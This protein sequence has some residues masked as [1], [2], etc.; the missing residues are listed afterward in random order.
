MAPAMVVKQRARARTFAFSIATGIAL[1]TSGCGLMEAP[2]INPKGP[3]ASAKRDIL[4]AAW[5]SC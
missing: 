3:I 2:I 5:R 4:S 1:L